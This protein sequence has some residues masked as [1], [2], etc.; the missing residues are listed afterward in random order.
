MRASKKARKEEKGE[1]EEATGGKDLE[2][3]DLVVQL[4]NVAVLADVAAEIELQQDFEAAVMEDLRE[5]GE[6]EDE[7]EGAVEG[8]DGDGGEGSEE[9]ARGEDQERIKRKKPRK[10][11]TKKFSNKI[12]ALYFYPRPP[13][14]TPSGVSASGRNLKKTGFVVYNRLTCGACGETF[15]KAYGLSTHSCPGKRGGAP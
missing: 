2:V 7:G 3:N 13:L 4:A 5:E 1:E 8:E 15:H 9:V 14:E 12:N 6:G 11:E 10:K